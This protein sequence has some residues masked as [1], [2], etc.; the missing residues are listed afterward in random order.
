MNGLETRK[1]C[2][3]AAHLTISGRAG[4]G[5]TRHVWPETE[6]NRQGANLTVTV[7]RCWLFLRFGHGWRQQVPGAGQI[8]NNVVGKGLIEASAGY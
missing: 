1:R 5:A 4:D 2:D 8:G 7:L 6:P 3:C